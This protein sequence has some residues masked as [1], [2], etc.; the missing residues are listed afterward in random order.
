MMRPILTCVFSLILA[1]NA[2]AAKVF[3]LI[4]CDTE[5]ENIESAVEVDCKRLKGLL[6]TAFEDKEIGELH[7]TVLKGKKATWANIRDYYLKE[8]KGKVTPDDALFFYYSGHGGISSYGNQAFYLSQDGDRTFRFIISDLM[9]Q[10][11]AKLN[12]FIYDCCSNRTERRPNIPAEASKKLAKPGPPLANKKIA[13]ALLMDGKGW[14]MIASSEAGKSSY[15][16][17]KIGGLFTS[18]LIETLSLDDAD[19]VCGGDSASAWRKAFDHS[20]RLTKE[21]DSR[22]QPLALYLADQMTHDF[23]VKI[24]NKTGEPI[25]FRYRGE[26]WGTPSTAQKWHT[27]EIKEGDSVLLP[28]KFW[29]IE[30]TAKGAVS[31]TKWKEEATAINTGLDYNAGPDGKKIRE[32]VITLT[33]K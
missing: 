6:L 14:V 8:L 33:A 13:K 20:A 27:I 7:L 12:I 9:E 17:D 28:E 24:R 19:K 5:A 23:A 2:F 32:H 3:V 18:S 22:Q 31:D 4:V 30:Y 25:T 29:L 21:K 10:H 16:D 1:Q 15:C 26:T 11:E